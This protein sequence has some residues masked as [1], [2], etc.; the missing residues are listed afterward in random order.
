MN[1]IPH[2]PSK[3]NA[4]RQGT[5]LWA[6]L[7]SLMLSV[8]LVTESC[9]SGNNQK[10][11]NNQLTENPTLA[12]TNEGQNIETNKADTV[13][14][15]NTTTTS[16][17][18]APK[19]L[20]N[21]V[22]PQPPTTNA[23]RETAQSTPSTESSNSSFS[24]PWLTGYNASNSLENRIA[25]PEGFKRTSV[26]ANSFAD[27]LRSL[28]LK[29][30]NPAVMLYNGSQKPNQSVHYA[31]FDIDVGKEDLQQCADAV[32]RLRA[33]YLWDRKLYDDIHFNYTSGDKA[34]YSQWRKG[35]RPVVSGNNVSWQKKED[36]TNST[37]Y[38]SF[39]QYMKQVFT[40]AGTLSLSKEMKSVSDVNRLEAGDVFIKGGSPGHAVIVLDVATNANGEKVFL[41]AQSYMPAQDIHVLI[42][43]NN[44]SLS[45]WYSTSEAIELNT[46][47]WNFN[48]NSLKRFAD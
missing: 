7:V 36:P 12:T 20:N 2:F 16:E 37:S 19:R 30:G 43:P 44:V 23:P 21:P 18:T 13:K 46:P 3:T 9:L 35:Y 29:S 39:K 24:Y 14:A 6:S 40:Y 27:W 26:T 33:E 4:V 41:L 28:P 8:L 22:V 31:V 42:N 45:P 5:L 32:M 17:N 38:A 25:P 11:T 15:N 34:A 47:E 48:A 1:P 10:Q